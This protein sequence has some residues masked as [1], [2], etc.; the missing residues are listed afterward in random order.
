[1]TSTLKLNDRVGETNAWGQRARE[2]Q[3]QI[4]R[5]IAAANAAIKKVGVPEETLKKA[6]DDLAKK[7]P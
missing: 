4:E 7:K 5:E 2:A 6:L 3:A 1:M